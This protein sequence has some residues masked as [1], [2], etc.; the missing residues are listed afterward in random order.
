MSIY[1]D[2]I[3]SYL[4][5]EAREAA[6]LVKVESIRH[7]TENN[8]CVLNITSIQGLQT[9]VCL[10]NGRFKTPKIHQVHLMIDILN[11]RHTLNIEKLPL[12]TDTID[13]NPWLSGFI[14]ADGSFGVR[15]TKKTNIV[16]KK[17]NRVQI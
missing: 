9:I 3:S 11:H 16:K 6:R 14:D 12:C 15:Y 4:P 2:N 13:T 10:I 17:Q 8:A 5:S 7:K 1:K